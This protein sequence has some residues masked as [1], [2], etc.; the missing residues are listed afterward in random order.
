MILDRNGALLQRLGKQAGLVTPYG[1]TL[2]KEGRIYVSE[3]QTGFL[4][5]LGPSGVLIDKIDLSE[6]RNKTVSPGR[7]AMG[8][9]G[10][11]Y[12][13][14]LNANEIL[15]LS[16]EGTRLHPLGNFGYL[17]KAGPGPDLEIIGL[18]GQGTAVTIFSADGQLLRSFGKHGDEKSRNVSFPSGFA[19]DGKNRLWI[20]DAF[21]HRLKVFSLT[22]EFLF[23]FGKMEEEDGG[24]FFPVDLC[25]GDHGE[26]YVLEKGADRIQV[27]QVEDL[28]E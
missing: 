8:Q 11:V 18:S 7:I 28:N 26:L 13:V 9:D 24:F 4:K 1:V 22:G 17:Q 25:F 20:A 27:F 10:E 3:V 2:D 21:Q 19:V 6:L 16:K 12:I 5:I 15:V 23:N 14:D